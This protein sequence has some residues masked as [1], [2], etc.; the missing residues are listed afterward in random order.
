MTDTIPTFST[1][2]AGNNQSTSLFPENLPPSQTTDNLRRLQAAIRNQWNQAQWFELGDLDRAATFAFIS[3]TQF[4]VINT[5]LASEYHVGRR[6]RARGTI[7]GRIVG[8]ITAVSQSGGN[9]D[10]T[11]NWDSGSLNNENFLI[12]LS[13]L[14]AIES[15]I[16]RVSQA[17]EFSGDNNFAG[18]VSVGGNL[19]VG[20]DLSGGS[21]TFDNV[22]F[23]SGP[24]NFIQA[25]RRFNGGP[26]II[27]PNNTKQIVLEAWG[28]GGGGSARGAPAAAGNGQ[29]LSITTSPAGREINIPGGAAG[30]TAPNGV[31]AGT[32]AATITGVTSS[33]VFRAV[34]DF[35]GLGGP[36]GAAAE[37]GI[38]GNPGHYVRAI[39]DAT[40]DDITSISI[41]GGAGGVGGQ[42]TAANDRGGNGGR[43]TILATFWG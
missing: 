25:Q 21:A 26:A 37:A 29:N 9:T 36:G 33:G 22:S 27:V 2:E 4:R 35:P 10:V 31:N 6:V 1:T 41:S 18:A 38:V 34:L 8:S 12:E 17:V 7:T 30:G 42:A 11:V 19:S 3:A 43:A 14:S 16:P 15:A 24:F 5:V 13:I 20:G 32:P 23:N 40:P 39:I 28:A